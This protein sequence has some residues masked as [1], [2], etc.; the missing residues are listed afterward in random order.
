M[1]IAWFSEMAF[2]GKTSRQHNNM[3]TE[4]AWFVAQ[5]AIHHN[6]MNLRQLP[7]N[8]YDV[9]ILIIPKHVSNYMQ[10][11]IITQLNRVCKKYA[12][13][14]EGPS[15]YFQDLPLNQSLWFYNLM[16]H[17]DFILA[18][19]DCDKKYYEGLLE[20]PCYINPT[21]MIEDVI[22]IE[23]VCRQ[24]TI[25]GGNLVRW[26]GGFNSLIVAQSINEPISVPQMGRM[27]QDELLLNELTH[28]P[29]MN[30]SEWISALNK[31]KYAVHLNPNSIAGTF[32][33]NCAYLGIPCIGNINSDTQRICF[34]ELSVDPADL[35]TAKK[36]LH[37][38]HVDTEF[39]LTCS[40]NAKKLYD[41]HFSE[42]RYINE[43]Q[44]IL[45][46]I[47]L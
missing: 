45:T 39:Y 9:G 41:Q 40:T 19:N 6:I 22:D 43:W 5:N 33:L 27:Q 17:A 37:K 30:W 23:N 15:W 21:L 7:D 38:L 32:S 20:K 3:R 12:F 29:Y 16:L 26:Y 35:K 4:F 34:P 44:S 36:L 13:M 1:E 47:N 42:S 18:H 2:D 8:A 25:I 46:Q 10:F 31:F 28:L 11:D 24:G 14:Q